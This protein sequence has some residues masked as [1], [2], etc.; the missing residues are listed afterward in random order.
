M[1]AGSPPPAPGW[2][3]SLTARPSST[4]RPPPAAH[5][6]SAVQRGRPCRRRG[7]LLPPR[8][9]PPGRRVPSALPPAGLRPP[10]PQ[11]QQV[12]GCEG[13][14]GCGPE[15]LRPCCFSRVPLMPPTSPRSKQKA[16][17]SLLAP[18]PALLVASSPVP[19]PGAAFE[20][21]TLRRGGTRASSRSA[22]ALAGRPAAAGSCSC[23]FPHPRGLRLR[24]RGAPALPPAQRQEVSAGG[25]PT[26]RG[27]RGPRAGAAFNPHPRPDRSR[28]CF[29][30]TRLSS[31]RVHSRWPEGC[32]SRL[33]RS[34]PCARSSHG[35]A[36][37]TF[38]SRAPLFPRVLFQK[39]ALPR[40]DLPIKIK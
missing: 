29:W 7:R 5:R 1:G 23:L 38:R 39:P 21:R 31:L 8:E 3:C 36:G 2:P 28:A 25:P 10:D 13:R 27:G 30:Q 17:R 24:P 33:S 40:Q 16:R 19:S 11:S 12:G 6:P 15:L 18:G 22:P 37:A 9:V 34:V 26:G 32:S 35:G 20:P 14:R 4:S